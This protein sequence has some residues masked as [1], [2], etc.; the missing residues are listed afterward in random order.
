M[1]LISYNK[2]PS[3]RELRVFGLGGGAILLAVAAVVA[4]SRGSGGGCG[5]WLVVLPALALLLGG[6]ALAAP[7][8]LKW[9]YLVLTAATW[10]IGLAVSFVLLG[11]FYFLIITPLGL[12]MRLLGRDALQMKPDPRRSSYWSAYVPPRSKAQYFNQF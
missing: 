10:P 8:A 7:A 2:N 1:S 11:A 4:L 5:A 3:R 6:T 12:A 9:V